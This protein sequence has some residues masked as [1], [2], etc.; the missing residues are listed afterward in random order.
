MG[1][2]SF[3]IVDLCIEHLTCQCLFGVQ[4]PEYARE[5]NE[6]DLV[7][8]LKPSSISVMFSVTV[9]YDGL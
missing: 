4:R 2:T 3:L 6:R 9:G 8:K 5:R 7:V 1:V